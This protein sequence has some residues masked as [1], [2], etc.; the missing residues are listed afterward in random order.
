MEQLLC[1]EQASGFTVRSWSNEM[2]K[3][4]RVI[5]NDVT[6]TWMAVSEIAKGRGKRSARKV[7]M[8]ASTLA[9]LMG[10]MGEAAAYSA[11]GGNDSGQADNVAIGTSSVNSDPTGGSVAIGLRTSAVGDI[12]GVAIGGHDTK[13]TGYF[14]VAVGTQATVAGGY[15]I[16][17][18]ANS[19]ALGQN[20]VALGAN[21]ISQAANLTTSGYNPGTGTL[22][23]ATG[24]GGE[25]SIGRT[26][27]ERRITNVAAGLAGS[28]AVNVSQL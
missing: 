17:I 19:T 26:G 22:V 24:A 4:Y 1:H 12:D 11:G 28:D 15:S 7:V 27:A 3:S 5:W 21:S 14:G 9:A 25:V 2:N 8:V 16:A 13:V 10:A 6:Q 20:S 18:G 23:A